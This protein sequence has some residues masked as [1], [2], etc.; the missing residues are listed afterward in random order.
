MMMIATFHA[1]FRSCQIV[2]ARIAAERPLLGHFRTFV[3]SRRTG[4]SCRPVVGRAAG[5]ALIA[6]G[7]ATLLV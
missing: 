4:V 3:G 2:V 1:D 6:W 7:G 5:T